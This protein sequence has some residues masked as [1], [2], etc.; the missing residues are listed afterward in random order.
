MVITILEARVAADK[1]AALEQ[2]FREAITQLDPGITQTFLLHSPTDPDL[3]RIATVWRDRQALDAMR[4]SPEPPRGIL[5]FRA[6]GAE[7]VLSIWDV[8]AHRTG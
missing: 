1:S 7:P 5:I 3:W 2:A 8:A 6:A 4:R